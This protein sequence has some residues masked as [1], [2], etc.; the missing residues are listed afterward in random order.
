M[1]ILNLLDVGHFFYLTS[2]LQ[3]LKGIWYGKYRRMSK[4]PYDSCDEYDE[5]QRNEYD[6]E[7]DDNDA[8]FDEGDDDENLRQEEFHEYLVQPKWRRVCLGQAIL[9]ISDRGVIRPK[10]SLFSSTKGFAYIGTPYRTYTVEVEPGVRKEYFVHDLVWRAFNGDPPEGWEVR[11][12][13]DEPLKRRKYYSNSLH[14][15][16]IVPST[17]TLRPTLFHSAA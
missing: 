11:H 9:D 8:Y 13:F 1:Y 17:V 12:T 2:C 5:D 10:C 3:S 4:K 7:F 6:D 15:L 16:T 14:C